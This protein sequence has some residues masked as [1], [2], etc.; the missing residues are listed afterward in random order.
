MSI[1][2]RRCGFS[3]LVVS[4]SFSAA[5]LLAASPASASTLYACVKK[6]GAARLYTKRPKCRKHEKRLSWNT[7]GPAGGDGALGAQGP[8]GRNGET[9][10][11]GTA[12]QPQ[13]ATVFGGSELGTIE[14]PFH[15]TETRT[16]PALVTLAGVSVR[17]KCEYFESEE[18]TVTMQ[19]LG[20]DGTRIDSGVS[21]TD[22]AGEPPSDSERYAF[23]E[24]ITPSGV[25]FAILSDRDEAT[26][27]IRAYVSSWITTA[28][29]IVVLD[30]FVEVNPVE[31]ADFGCSTSGIAYVLPT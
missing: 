2:F 27:I 31:V 21:A 6:S 4:V 20:P 11:E 18:F 17:M 8:A 30:A 13:Q 23:N 28:S 7:T 26:Q 10:K 1:A 12:G 22:Q 5:A 19:A 14:H 15:F 16:T 29:A 9:G 24:A 3:A 25:P